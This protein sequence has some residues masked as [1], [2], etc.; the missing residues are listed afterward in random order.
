LVPA[1]RGDGEILRAV[2]TNS[3][4][5]ERNQPRRQTGG[6]AANERGTLPV[7]LHVVGATVH[8]CRIELGFP[9]CPPFVYEAASIPAPPREQTGN[10]ATVIA[11]RMIRAFVV[12]FT[13]L[14]IVR[15]R[16]AR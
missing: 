13:F 14:P 6:I 1:P 7:G 10:T 12:F 16:S 9:G 2:P 5:A 15:P 4:G 11:A 3:F 8:E